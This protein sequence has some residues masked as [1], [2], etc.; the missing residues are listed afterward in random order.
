M[1]DGYEIPFSFAPTSLQ[2]A[3]T[4]VQTPLCKLLKPHF[5]AQRMDQLNNLFNFCKDEEVE[6]SFFEKKKWNETKEVGM[7]LRELWDANIV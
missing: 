2:E 7:I 5:S 1:I 4:E 6:Y 3:L